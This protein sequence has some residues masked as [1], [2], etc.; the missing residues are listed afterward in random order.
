MAIDILILTDTANDTN[1]INTNNTTISK[2]QTG[3]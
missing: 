3:T 1:A 2:E